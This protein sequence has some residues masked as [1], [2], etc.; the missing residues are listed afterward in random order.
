MTRAPLDAPD[1]SAEV[2]ATLGYCLRFPPRQTKRVVCGIQPVVST[3]K[4]WCGEYAKGE[5]GV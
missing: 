1:L 2:V 3:H 4:D 5:R